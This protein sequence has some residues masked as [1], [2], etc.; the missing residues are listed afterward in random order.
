MSRI[1]F[2]LQKTICP[3]MRRCFGSPSTLSQLGQLLSGDYQQC[4]D[5]CVSQ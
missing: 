4:A 1:A 5:D 3:L 2:D